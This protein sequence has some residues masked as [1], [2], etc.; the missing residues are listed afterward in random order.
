M[1]GIDRKNACHGLP[2]IGYY[3]APGEKGQNGNGVYFG[4]INDFFDSEFI[5]FDT[6][7]RTAPVTGRENLEGYTGLIRKVFGENGGMTDI[8]LVQARWN[9]MDSIPLA[10]VQAIMNI[11]GTGGLEQYI[12]ELIAEAKTGTGYIP[13]DIQ[14]DE[15]MKAFIEKKL[16]DIEEL[17]QYLLLKREQL[18]EDG[19]IEEDKEGYSDFGHTVY[20]YVGTDSYTDIER[21]KGYTERYRYEPD[22]TI[23]ETKVM[24]DM[25]HVGVN[26]TNLDENYTIPGTTGDQFVVTDRDGIDTTGKP[27]GN[28]GRFR[29]GVDVVYATVNPADNSYAQRYYTQDSYLSLKEMWVKKSYAD[30]WDPKNYYIKAAIKR[31]MNAQD[32]D[33]DT[34]YDLEGNSF[35]Y[36]PGYVEQ[37]EHELNIRNMIRSHYIKLAETNKYLTVTQVPTDQYVNYVHWSSYSTEK[38]ALPTTLKADLVPGDVLYLWLDTFNVGRTTP[39]YMVVVTEDLMGCKFDTFINMLTIE[40]P[41]Q[42]NVTEAVGDRVR[43]NSK[44]TVARYE[45]D[46]SSELQEELNKQDSIAIKYVNRFGR[47]YSQIINKKDYQLILSEFDTEEA[48][49]RPG[50]LSRLLKMSAGEPQNQKALALTFD[51]QSGVEPGV[52]TLVFSADAGTKLLMSSMYVSDK[53]MPLDFELGGLITPPDLKIDDDGFIPNIKDDDL[54]EDKIGI[55]LRKANIVHSA[56]VKNY[57]KY[58]IGAYIR[59]LDSTEMCDVVADSTG[60]VKFPFGSAQYGKTTQYTVLGYIYDMQGGFRH[61]TKAVRVTLTADNLG[62]IIER[63]FTYDRSDYTQSGDVAGT[64]DGDEQVTLLMDDLT[65]GHY[66]GDMKFVFGDDVD[67]SSVKIYVNETEI[68]KDTDFSWISFGKPVVVG[69]TETMLV[70]AS[71]NIPNIIDNVDAEVPDNVEQAM[72]TYSDEYLDEYFKD[73]EPLEIHNARLFT[74]INDGLIR[75]SLSRKV[76]VSVTY[77]AKSDGRTHVSVFNVTQPGF[78]DTRTLPEVKFTPLTSQVELE[79]SNVYENGVLPNQF[80]FF[81]DIDIKKFTSDDWGKYGA[82][83]T[84][85]LYFDTEKLNYDILDNTLYPLVY[86]VPSVRL[87]PDEDIIR[88]SLYEDK[89]IPVQANYVSLQTLA[90]PINTDIGLKV[91]ELEKLA[92]TVNAEYTSRY[93]SIY[94]DIGFERREYDREYGTSFYGD[95]AQMEWGV[96]KYRFYRDQTLDNNE[97]DI[98]GKP[99]LLINPGTIDRFVNPINIKSGIYK[100]MGVCLKDIRPSDIKDG[101]FKLWVRFEEG[102]PVP[103]ALNLNFVLKKLVVHY[104]LSDGRNVTFTYGSTDERVIGDLYNNELFS[105]IT[106]V[107]LSESEYKKRWKHMTG[108]MEFVVNP[109]TMVA[110]PIACEE[111]YRQI[112]PSIKMT[113]PEGEVTVGLKLFGEQNIMHDSAGL[114]EPGRNET[115]EQ[116]LFD[117]K[118]WQLKREYFQDDIRTLSVNVKNPFLDTFRNAVSSQD[119]FL[120]ALDVYNDEE[121]VEM[122][123]VQT[124]TNWLSVFVNDETVK[125]YAGTYLGL[126]WNVLLMLPKYRNDQYTFYYNDKL[127]EADRYDQ[128]MR[129]MPLLLNQ[130]F[131]YEIR[132]DKLI[133]S[134][135]VWNFEYLNA[136]YAD[137]FSERGVVNRYGY[138]YLDLRPAADYGQYEKDGVYSLAETKKLNSDYIL[139]TWGEE[140]VNYA[141][142]TDEYTPKTGKYFRGLLY[143]AGWEVPCYYTEDDENYCIPWRLRTGTLSAMDAFIL[144]S[145][146]GKS[147]DTPDEVYENTVYP[148]GKT[149]GSVFKKSVIA[150]IPITVLDIIEGVYDLDYLTTEDI[151]LMKKNLDM[152][153][154][155]GT[156]IVAWKSDNFVSFDPETCVDEVIASKKTETGYVD[157]GVPYTWCYSVY[158]RTTYNTTYDIHNILMLRCPAVTKEDEYD[159][160]HIYISLDGDPVKLQPPYKVE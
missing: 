114:Y 99:C 132:D 65:C 43:M 34:F 68:T 23:P 94:G 128:F 60:F 70:L 123:N 71:N 145:A 129:N 38:L 144:C 39:D 127:Y 63:G 152:G 101:K 8:E 153:N 83:V 20:K 28:T 6:I 1:D 92:K 139:H 2:G 138:G 32:D 49:G 90:L 119:A 59:N 27:V 54:D 4:H 159:L 30:D 156:D 130:D 11:Y 105:Y 37:R 104:P 100:G 61:F 96:D 154:I 136:S 117:W 50:V 103:S 121:T 158:P 33:D 134:V 7:V 13:P 26:G 142:K 5:D 137:I 73:A 122:M 22:S 102:D 15:Q 106:N 87:I 29:V 84:L 56:D 76:C 51:N 48:N 91:S 95:V 120:H 147:G 40:K 25:M 133:E 155:Q 9:A 141:D 89:P 126:V 140:T 81:I 57:N 72:A 125:P 85:D 53:T 21:V 157:R 46:E 69:N 47:N 151:D 55:N 116:Q 3:G 149:S 148:K 18:L 42:Y 146:V 110:A 150:E 78:E 24:V 80:Q 67:M 108:N 124:D 93:Y 12:D 62:R 160:S 131:S 75:S 74:R 19:V 98:F 41:F 113:G 35:I 97:I 31:P 36:A 14:N 88:K 111:N 17:K 82:D 77:T 66:E 109:L 64:P 52:K 16:K 143:G 58:V 107:A 10:Q 118:K 86:D 45:L 79:K 44:L 115:I 135:D 112:Y